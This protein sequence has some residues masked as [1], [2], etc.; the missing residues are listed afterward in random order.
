MGKVYNT[1][2][3]SV[4]YV[5]DTGGRL[6]WSTQRRPVNL[7]P[8]ANW[9]YPAVT[10]SFPDFSKFCNYAHQR[11]SDPNGGPPWAASGSGDICQTVT[12]IDELQEWAGSDIYLGSVP[13]GVN[14]IDVRVEISVAKAPN[15]FLDQAVPPLVYPGTW[16]H[17]PGGSCLIEATTI[18]RR[19]FDVVLVGTDIYLRRRQSVCAIPPN[20][21]ADYGGIYNTQGANRDPW[22]TFSYADWGWVTGPGGPMQNSQRNGH[23]AALIEVKQ[24]SANN[25]A[26]VPTMGAKHP[27]RERACSVNVAQHDFSSSYN[28]SFIVRPGYMP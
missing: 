26:S 4:I 14:Y 7:L 12:M 20:A 10:I 5:E 17:L 13:A 25:G 15:P 27:T 28:A 18:W 3:T 21:A 22:L 11:V 1:P 24:Y 2:G 6:V 16:V 23:P 9:L 8:A 19:L